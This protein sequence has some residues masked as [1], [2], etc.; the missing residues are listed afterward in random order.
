VRT[1][2]CSTLGWSRQKFTQR[3]VR[4]QLTN[5]NIKGYRWQVTG[6]KLVPFKEARVVLFTCN[7]TNR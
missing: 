3:Q 1:K 4:F 2:F 5:R 7:L 6:L